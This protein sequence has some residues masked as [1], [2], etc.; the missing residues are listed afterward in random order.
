MVFWNVAFR[1]CCPKP[2]PA[3][4]SVVKTALTSSSLHM[5]AKNYAFDSLKTYLVLRDILGYT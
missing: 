4:V 2:K 3:P 5:D 1:H